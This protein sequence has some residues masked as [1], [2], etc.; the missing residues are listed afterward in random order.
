M[1]DRIIKLLEP[2]I[3]YQKNKSTI[4]T[5]A[6]L[7]LYPV[8]K[9]I[10][11]WNT[12]RGR[13]Y[14]GAIYGANQTHFHRKPIM[15]ELVDK[16]L[17]KSSSKIPF[18]ILEIGSWAG[19]SAILWAQACKKQKKGLVYCIDTWKASS[20]APPIMKDAV[21]R[22]KIF[23]L[24]LHNL[25]VAKVDDYVVVLKGT[26]DELSEIIKPMSFDIV[27][28]DGDHSYT[29]FKKDLLSYKEL[30]KDGG[31][32][33]GDDLEL[34]YDLVIDKKYAKKHCDED[35][36][37]NPN[38]QEYYHPGIT[39]AIYEVFGDVSQ[40]NGFWAMRKEKNKWKEVLL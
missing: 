38:T 12:N 17:E 5:L 32:L 16:E 26:S 19:E 23:P 28:I 3:F 9:I 29:Q 6:R 1:R 15:Q 21:V 37:I 14:I 4:F 25:K 18:R 7:I 11:L 39:L 24:F 33:C 35:K 10:Y 27:Y 8:R 22:S 40:K 36:I 34:T 20:N 31:I 2:T 30:V 13:S